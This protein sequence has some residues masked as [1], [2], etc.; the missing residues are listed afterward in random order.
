MR[1]TCL[2]R[3]FLPHHTL[4][5]LEVLFLIGPGNNGGDGLVIAKNLEEAGAFINLYHW[6][7]HKL[8]VRGEDI[9]EADTATELESAISSA[10]YIVDALLGTRQLTAINR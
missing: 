3:T 8:S 2:K 4:N 10:D 5:G 1:Q 7:E 6:K 9:S